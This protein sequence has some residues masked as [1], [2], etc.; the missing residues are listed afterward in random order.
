MQKSSWLGLGGV[1]TLKALL[2]LLIAVFALLVGLNN[3]VDYNSNFMFVQHVLAMDTT[4]AGNTQM[5]R[6]VAQPWLHHAAYAVIILLEFSTGALC[7][8]GAWRMYQQRQAVFAQFYPGLMLASWGLAL[9]LVL[10]F[11]GF[12]VVGAEWFLM[13]QSD[14]WNGQDAAFRFLV[15]IIATLIFIHLPEPAHL[16][17]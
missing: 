4:F 1:R 5:W 9:G 11:G 8:A 15:S 16:E 12:M 17:N 7:L 6:A 2:V 13:W 14:S 10:W 3:V